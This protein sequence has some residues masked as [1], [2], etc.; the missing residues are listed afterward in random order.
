MGNIL[1]FD[2]YVNEEL[3]KGVIDRSK[4]DTTRLEDIDDFDRSMKTLCDFC[5]EYMAK[6]MKIDFSDNLCT[7]DDP[8]EDDYGRLNVNI[9]FNFSEIGTEFGEM[10]CDCEF[11]DGCLNEGD[12]DEMWTQFFDIFDKWQDELDYEDYRDPYI[13]GKREFNKIKKILLGLTKEI[14]KNAFLK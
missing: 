2:E 3:W 10:T 14:Q 4:T 12:I 8:N 13:N 6:K 7:Y 5:G 11:K 9:N 1:N